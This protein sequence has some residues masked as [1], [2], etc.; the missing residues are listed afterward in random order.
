MIFP[1]FKLAY[2]MKRDKTLLKTHNIAV[3]HDCFTAYF[4]MKLHSKENSKSKF[5]FIYH[6]DGNLWSML[7]ESYPKLSIFKRYL[8]LIENSIIARCDAIIL[9]SNS[10]K[11]RLEFIKG[12]AV[13]N[14]LK[15]IYNGIPDFT[16]KESTTNYDNDSVN[17]VCVGTLC[18][19]KG[20]DRCLNLLSLLPFKMRGKIKLHFVGDGSFREDLKTQSL[21]LSL[22]EQVF[23]HGAKDDV[24][25]YVAEADAYI[26]LSRNEGLPLSIIEAMSLGL[27]IL[28]TKVGGVGELVID[29][30]NGF[31][32]DDENRSDCLQRFLSL[33]EDDLNKMKLNSRAYFEAN[34][35]VD[36]MIDNECRLFKE[37]FSYDGR[38]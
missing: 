31:I 19:R 11:S 2:K 12:D 26:L 37:V 6:N 5:I 8:D 34:F 20:Q 27:P 21:N 16:D 10:A 13:N 36:K 1:A 32:Y 17:I 33:S 23:F 15:V 9:L 25:P 18:H 4:L 7:L 35:T 38:S 28:A 14:K 22:N 30:F 24:Y 29:G 3:V